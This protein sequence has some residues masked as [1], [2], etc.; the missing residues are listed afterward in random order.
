MQVFMTWSSLSYLE[1]LIIEF[2]FL[3]ERII[4]K[5]L[6]MGFF[7]YSVKKCVLKISRGKNLKVTGTVYIFCILFMYLVYNRISFYTS[8][9]GNEQM[10]QCRKL[11]T[12]LHIFIYTAYMS[13]VQLHVDNLI[14]LRSTSFHHSLTVLFCMFLTFDETSRMIWIVTLIK[15]SCHLNKKCFL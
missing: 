9:S 1:K 8:R 4:M 10:T 7:S 5:T 14:S 3:I 15:T 6:A 2:Q 11:F 12:F 13:K